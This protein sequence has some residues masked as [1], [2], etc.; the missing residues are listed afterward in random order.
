[1]TALVQYVQHLKFTFRPW[2]WPFA[3]NRRGEIDEFFRR[4]CEKNPALWNGRLLLLRSANIRDGA[5]SGRFFEIDYA[6]MLAALDWGGMG[7]AVKACFPAAAVL[8]SDGGF[9]LGEM[10]KHTRNAG[11]VVFPCGSAERSDVINSWVDFFGTLRRELREETG[12]VLDTLLPESGWYA[13]TV[14]PRLPV[15]KIVR[16]NEPAEGLRARIVANLAVQQRSEF[17]EILI[18]RGL[19]DLSERMPAWVTGFLRHFWQA[20]TSAASSIHTRRS[21]GSSTR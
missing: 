5:M 20:R 11:E 9:I 4:E 6:S 7:D 13:V 2:L 21:Q 18:V 12:I 16:A 3:E 14:G 10:A 1:M 15:I 8:A 19:S 17:S